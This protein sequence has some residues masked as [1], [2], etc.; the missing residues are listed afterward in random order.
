MFDILLVDANSQSAKTLT[1]GTA[2]GGSPD[3]FPDIKQEHVTSVA[4]SQFTDGNTDVVS[5]R[6]FGLAT[7]SPPSQIFDASLALRRAVNHLDLA[8]YEPST[9]APLPSVRSKQS[10]FKNNAQKVHSS[11]Q[12]HKRTCRHYQPHPKEVDVPKVKPKSIVA[13]DMLSEATGADLT[14]P[15]ISTVALA[16]DV[17]SSA[18]LAKSMMPPPPPPSIT[19]KSLMFTRLLLPLL[20][21]P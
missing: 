2:A 12:A 8:N 1:S 7:F 6:P 3:Q 21:F 18:P 4:D 11:R 20:C 15:S 16:T 5:R 13:T 14:F 10:K 19:R 17:P 9:I